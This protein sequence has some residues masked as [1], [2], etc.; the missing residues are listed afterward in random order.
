MIRL[1]ADIFHHIAAGKEGKQRN[2]QPHP[3]QVIG[4]GIAVVIG[5]HRREREGNKGADIDRH[6][7]QGKRP[8]QPRIFW[9]V[10]F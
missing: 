3:A 6:I 8:I 9:L 7:E 10:A 1:G 4:H 2:N 5:N